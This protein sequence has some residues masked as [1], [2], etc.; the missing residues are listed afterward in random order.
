[1]GPDHT[2]IALQPPDDDTLF[3]RVSTAPDL[4]ALYVEKLKA[5]RPNGPYIL[6]GYSAGALL[7]LE[8]AQQLREQNQE[9]PLLVLLDPLFLRY[10]RLEQVIYG[11]LKVLIERTKR[12]AREFRHY[13]ILWAMIQDKGL[14]RHLLALQNYKPKP[15]AGRIILVEAKWSRFLRP[16]TFIAS[17]K[18][19]AKCGLERHRS[20]GDHHTFL[21]APHA[22]ELGHQLAE[23]IRCLTHD[24]TR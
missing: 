23:W 12:Y 10:S 14:E 2:L 6:G 16:P 7:A 5:L 19:I 21:R 13:N 20:R 24:H 15:Y 1:M 17:W 4:A 22:G 9:V 11:A 18:K 8:M 3:A